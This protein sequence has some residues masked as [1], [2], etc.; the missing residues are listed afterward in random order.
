MTR[1]EI[2]GRNCKVYWEPRVN[3]FVCETEDKSVGVVGT[4]AE[5][6]IQFMGEKLTALDRTTLGS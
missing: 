1:V 6:A 4:T 3:R 2:C 5:Q